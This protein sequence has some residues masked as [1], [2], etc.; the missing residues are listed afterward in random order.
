MLHRRKRILHFIDSAGLYGAEQVILNLSREMSEARDFEPVV[1]CIVTTVDERSDLYDAA[2]AAGIEAFKLQI[3]NW[4]LPIDLL[5]VAR[6][7]RKAQICLVHSHGYKPSVFAYLMQVISGAPAMATCHLWFRPEQAPLR[8][9]VMIWIERVLYRRF[10]IVVAVSDSIRCILVACGVPP[11]RVRL[12]P[13]G[14]DVSNFASL[15]ESRASV[16]EELGLDVNTLCVLNTARLTE[17]KSQWVLVEATA[18][19]R[20]EGVAILT[21]IVGQGED[22]EILQQS[23]ADLDV[24]DCVRLLGFRADVHRLLAAADVFALPSLE[25]GMPISLLEA[26][27]ARVPVVTTAVGDIPKLI[28][29]GTSGW[30]VPK[31]DPKAMARSIL[32]IRDDRSSA[33]TIAGR[34]HELLVGTYVSRSMAA[35]YLS[36]YRNLCDSD[37]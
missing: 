20:R 10:R 11:S 24:D 18:A 7:L 2:V 32:Q 13:N 4:L 28:R 36:I 9:R 5:R 12:V 25:E 14:I 29:H 23:I 17:Q 8:S 26:V 35:E 27:A 1:G 22:R 3:R 19:L 33:R 37:S 6:R 34:A 15:P 30:I 16:R 31:E 21:L